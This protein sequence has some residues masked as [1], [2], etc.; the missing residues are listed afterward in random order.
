MDHIGIDVHKRESQICILA[1]G[2]ELIE[3]RI[4]TEP[5]RFAAVLGGR[6][7][8]R[9]VIEASADSAWVARCLEAL[10]HEVVVAD[11]NFAPM[12]AS[13]TRKVKT[14]R[15][16][17]RALPSAL[18]RHVLGHLGSP[19]ALDAP[20][21]QERPGDGQRSESADS[22]TIALWGQEFARKVRA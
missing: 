6:P 2:G 1:E 20:R 21:Q 13:R 11:P 10:G 8:P 9:V 3:R 12:Y 4:L 16:D 18:R 7:P 14:D 17:A 22:P 5:E 15:R 19:R